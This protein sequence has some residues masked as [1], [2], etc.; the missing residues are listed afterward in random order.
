MSQ[1][2]RITPRTKQSH[3]KPSGIS[4]SGPHA[5]PNHRPP[6]PLHLLQHC[7][8]WLF[9]QLIKEGSPRLWD[10]GLLVA[11]KSHTKFGRTE[12]QD[13][14][15][16]QKNTPFE[17]LMFLRFQASP[18]VIS[19][20]S[21]EGSC[22]SFNVQVTYWGELGG[23]FREASDSWF[24]LS[25]FSQEPEIQ[26]LVGFLTGHE[27]FLGFSASLFL[28]P[29]ISKLAFPQSNYIKNNKHELQ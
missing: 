7:L 9:D 4:L 6:G 13:T 3:Y 22:S 5:T 19:L 17:V 8:D 26:P 27:T 2:P 25:T 10:R 28:S 12:K 15:F 11:L 1:V 24:Q 18:C 14:S 21:V 20:H 23:S 16:T 29:F